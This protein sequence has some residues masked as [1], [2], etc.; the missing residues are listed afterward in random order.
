MALQALIQQRLSLIVRF[1]EGLAPAER[2]ARAAVA[3]ADQLGDDALRGA[4]MS[5]L[6]L[7]RFNAGKPGALRLA[8]EAYAL[9][10]GAAALQPVADAGFALG[11]I[12]V[13][14]GE[15]D[16]ARTLLESLYRDWSERDERTAAYA[17]WYLALIE[18]RSGRLALAGEYAQE[19]RGLSSQY[20]R[21]EAESPQTL[22]PMTLVALYRGDLELARGLAER[23]CAARRAPRLAAA[24]AR[25]DR[26]CRR[27]V[28]RRLG[29]SCCALRGRGAGGR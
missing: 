3:L 13:W 23:L 26:R 10:S 21:D 2:H 9:A 20:A 11:H 5:G 7:I 6:A 14:S 19:S 28:E 18:F 16:R 25:G 4:A 15:L 27:A 17:L 29:G 8:E 1:S 12:L 22:F 24:G